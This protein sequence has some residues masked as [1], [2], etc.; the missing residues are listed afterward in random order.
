MNFGPIA[1]PGS[2]QYT[3]LNNILQRG[4][5][6]Q[7]TALVPLAINDAKLDIQQGLSEAGNPTQFAD[8]PDWM[9]GDTHSIVTWTGAAIPL[10]SLPVANP[11]IGV[12]NSVK[13]VKAVYLACLLSDGVSYTRGREIAPTT[14]DAQAAGQQQRRRGWGGSDH[15]DGCR[16]GWDVEEFGIVI[17]NPEILSSGIKLWVDWNGYLTNYAADGDNDWFSN[18]APLALLYKAAELGCISM[19]RDDR[20][21]FFATES[22]KRIAKARTVDERMRRAGT[23]DVAHAQIPRFYGGT[24]GMPRGLRP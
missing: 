11:G 10:A 22:A 15:H 9:A 16:N 20:Q 12:P 7:L 17:G 18:F 21:Q 14:R 6:A 3:L 1:T 23:A 13:R 4:T 5:N 8:V 2:L 19:W 24:V